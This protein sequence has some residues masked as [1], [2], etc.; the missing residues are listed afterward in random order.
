MQGILGRWAELSPL[1]DELLILGADVR[2]GRLADLRRTD[3]ALAAELEDLLSSQATL[4]RHGFLELSHPAVVNAY[5]GRA[6]ASLA[7]GDRAAALADARRE[8][9]GGL[10]SGSSTNSS[11][12]GVSRRRRTPEDTGQDHPVP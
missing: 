3:P 7:Q 9:R 2:A 6:E 4:D 5:C 1:L 10:A 12:P 11:P 8:G